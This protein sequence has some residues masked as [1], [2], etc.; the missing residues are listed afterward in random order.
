[1]AAPLSPAGRGLA[2]AVVLSTAAHA[3]LFLLAD[4]PAQ[5]P[6]GSG[7]GAGVS[8]HL[9]AA[10]G[11]PGEETGEEAGDASEG[12]EPEASPARAEAEPR[13]EPAPKEEPTGTNSEQPAPEPPEPEAS[14]ESQR[15]EATATEA[16][17][18]SRDEE[19]RTSTNTAPERANAGE[20][21]DTAADDATGAETTGGGSDQ[22]EVDPG[23]LRAE[24]RGALGEHFRYPPVAVRRGWEGEV[25]LA[26]RVT[27]EGDIRDI[28]VARGSGH[29]MLD[30]AARRALQRVARLDPPG[31]VMELEL[32]VVFRLEG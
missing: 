24:A 19:A 8:V 12:G 13:K 1:M 14:T 17:P 26:F 5:A 16:S 29:A 21:A 27:A 23:H 4:P 25:R 31:R 10:G 28:E 9:A 22:P 30:D 15:A 6:G 7:G 32:P 3:G 11:A 2:A 18:E 20:A